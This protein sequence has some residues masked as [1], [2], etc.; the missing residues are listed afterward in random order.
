MTK[1]SALS[2]STSKIMK[3]GSDSL[4]AKRQQK[5]RRKDNLF[6]K[7]YEYSILCNALVCVTICL[8]D[9]G[10]HFIFNSDNTGKWP[11]SATEMVLNFASFHSTMT[12]WTDSQKDKQYPMPIQ[13]TLEDLEVIAR[14]R[15]LK[16]RKKKEQSLTCEFQ[17]QEQQ[18]AED[19]D[20]ARRGLLL[21]L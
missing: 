18:N 2:Q 13:M 17:E 15:K 8:K 14:S 4:K 9:S 10:Q 6:V 11:L 19:E 1:P 12:V 16:S 21:S 5:Y 3:K 20:N 7:A